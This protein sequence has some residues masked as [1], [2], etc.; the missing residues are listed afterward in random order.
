MMQLV[1]PINVPVAANKPYR[2]RIIQGWC[3]QN[4][5]ENMAS[6]NV[7]GLADQYPNGM[8]VGQ[9]APNVTTLLRGGANLAQEPTHVQTLFQAQSDFVGIYGN[10]QN[11]AQYPSN[12]YMVLSDTNVIMSPQAETPGAAAGTVDRQFRPYT[13]KFNFT[14]NKQLR[15]S[16]STTAAA[17]GNAEWFSP[18]NTPGEWI[19]FITVS[20]LNGPDE[21][22]STA[23]MPTCKMTENT[24]FLD[25]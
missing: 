6:T 17:V 18:I 23:Y 9:N 16:A 1:P 25:N 10:H 4:P 5:V 19:P 7:V 2:L 20:V 13:R 3:K 22:T 12:M 11:E 14:C 21:F 24:F 8:A 15:L